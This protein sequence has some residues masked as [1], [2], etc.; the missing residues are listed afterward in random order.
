MRPRPAGGY[1]RAWWRANGH[2]PAASFD[3][4]GH[5]AW[6]AVLAIVERL[7][8]ATD[9]SHPP[10]LSLAAVDDLATLTG[11]LSLPDERVLSDRVRLFLG[12]WWPW[13]RYWDPFYPSAWSAT[14]R[15]WHR[16]WERGRR[17][18]SDD[19]VT[20]VHSRAGKAA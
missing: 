1:D 20:A 16:F 3:L 15:R 19:G 10:T 4:S 2:L 17:H 8:S 14:D 5:P 11:Y 9:Q 12:T 13:E 6:A 7:I 18:I